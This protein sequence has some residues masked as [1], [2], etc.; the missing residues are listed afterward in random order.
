MKNNLT[1]FLPLALGL[2]LIDRLTKYLSLT[3]PEAGIFYWPGFGLKLYLNSGLAFSLPL[4]P[5][6]IAALVIIILIALIIVWAKW[7]QAKK[8]A[9]L[10]P[11]TLIILGAFSNLLDRFKFGAVIDFID[12][13]F[14]PAFNLADLYIVAGGGWLLL[15]ILPKENK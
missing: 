8:F 3:L 9:L 7:Y 6:L 11:L 2:F 12:L 10:W 5:A 13:W 1:R 15:N 14:W 4:S